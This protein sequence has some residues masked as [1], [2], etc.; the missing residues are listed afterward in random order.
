MIDVNIAD[1]ATGNSTLITSRGQLV[2]G[3]LDYSTAYTVEANVINTAFNFV[4]PIIGKRFVLTDVLLYANK[5]VGAADATVELYET[6]SATSTTVERAI[7]TMEMLK[8]TSRDMT[9]LNLICTAGRW[10]NIK[11]DDNTVFATIMGYYV[12]V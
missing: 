11:T 4:G 12:N 6:T 8:Q 7:L 2:T 1:R 9:G 10:I 5:G 3:A